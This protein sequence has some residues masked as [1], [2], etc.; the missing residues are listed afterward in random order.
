M[1]HAQ[2]SED[3]LPDSTLPS[4]SC[5]LPFQ[6]AHGH[7]GEIV[8]L[9]GASKTLVGLKVPKPADH[10]FAAEIRRIPNQIVPRQPRAM[11]EKVAGRRA[12]LPRHDLV[13]YSSDFSREH[14]VGRLR[15]LKPNKSFRS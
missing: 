1:R 13:W 10:M 2:R 12:G 3:S 7:D 6:I 14:M 9:V 15:Y 5:E 11:R 4:Q 8:V